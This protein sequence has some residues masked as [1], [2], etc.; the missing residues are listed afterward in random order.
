MSDS[1]VFMF[2]ENGYNNNG[3]FGFGGWGGGILGFLLGAMFANGGMFGGWG[4]RNNGGYSDQLNGDNNTALIMNAING[5]NADV[6][7]LATNLNTDVNQLQNAICE[8]RNAIQQVSAQNG[9]S[10]LQ[11]QNAIL[12]GDASLASQIAQCCCENRLLTTQQGYEGRIQTIEQTNALNGTINANGRS[13][14]DA[15]AAQT[16]MITKQFCDLKE[17]EMQSKIDTQAE[18]ITQ[19]RNNENNA[20]QTKQ[21][22]DMI[23]PLQQQINAIA[24]KQPNTVPVQWPQITAVNTTPNI[25]GYGNWGWNNG[26]GSN[27]FWN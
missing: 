6:R 23:V 14:T 19:L 26:W 16:T 11:I 2:P 12:S 18:I 24:A 5:T 27:S 4:N 3:G 25:N 8:I 9:M 13:I 7:M 21:I 20:A 10:A 15:I 17:R 22:Y 1:K